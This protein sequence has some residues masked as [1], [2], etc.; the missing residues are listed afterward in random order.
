[1]QS[2]FESEILLHMQLQVYKW[3]K[4]R[5]SK[6]ANNVKIYHQRNLSSHSLNIIKK[7][8]PTIKWVGELY[9]TFHVQGLIM[10]KEMIFQK[11]LTKVRLIK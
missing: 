8:V 4:M 11:I 9:S 10:L 1:M 5:E 7:T 2:S 6:V 3:T